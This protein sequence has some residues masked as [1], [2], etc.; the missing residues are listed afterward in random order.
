MIKPAPSKPF[1][2]GFEF[3]ETRRTLPIALLRARE[4]LMER[5]R[6]I[7]NAHDVTE[8]QWRILRIL[9]EGREI[10][11][12]ALAERSCVLAPS[13]TRML[14]ALVSRGLIET[15][16]DPKDGRRFLISITKEGQNFIARLAPES[17][18]IY[19]QIEAKLGHARIEQLLDDL[20]EVLQVLR[21]D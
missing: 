14:R 15:A 10:N 7:L 1:K 13:L 12:T 3:A 9:Q 17:A 18:A 16:K 19:A 11:A 8:Q 2:D 21:Q 20:G 5:F 4:A 6:P